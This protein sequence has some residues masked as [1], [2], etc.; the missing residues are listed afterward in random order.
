MK[1]DDLP[2][3]ACTL[4]YTPAQVSVLLGSFPGRVAE[5]H[6]WMREHQLQTVECNRRE[7]GRGP[8]GTVYS[9]SDLRTFLLR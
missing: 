2:N 6:E 3:P 9:T 7:A 4:G 5:L 1:A 8:H